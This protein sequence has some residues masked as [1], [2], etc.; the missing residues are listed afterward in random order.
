[1][2]NGG[3]GRKTIWDEGRQARGERDVQESIDL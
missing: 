1:M 3:H 2:K